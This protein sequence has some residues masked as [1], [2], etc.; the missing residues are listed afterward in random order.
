MQL[1]ILA[2]VLIAIAIGGIAIK[3]LLKPGSTFTKTCGSTFDPRT[4]RAKPCSCQ[5]DTPEDCE[6]IKEES[7]V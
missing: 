7:T 2:I 1:F 5:S 6:S 4:G 3:M